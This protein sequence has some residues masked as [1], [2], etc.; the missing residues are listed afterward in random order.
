[1]NGP[2]KQLTARWV[3]EAP[4]VGEWLKTPLGRTAYEIVGVRQRKPTLE[5]PNTFVLTVLRHLPSE[6]P[7]GATVHAFE[8]AK[9][10]RRSRRLS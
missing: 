10:Q 1:M 5:A 4:G 8:W 3:G 9:R 7:P 2:T 6:I